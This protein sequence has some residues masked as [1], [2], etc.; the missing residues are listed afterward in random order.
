MQIGGGGRYGG[1]L[2]NYGYGGE[3]HFVNEGS[4]SLRPPGSCKEEI[5]GGVK[6]WFNEAVSIALEILNMRVVSRID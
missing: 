2:G 5:G 1:G 4:N 6:D 3:G